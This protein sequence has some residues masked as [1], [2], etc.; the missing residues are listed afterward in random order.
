M[1]L[2]KILFYKL[3]ELIQF[4]IVIHKSYL[5]KTNTKIA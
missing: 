2:D 5:V 3:Y 4:D 1:F